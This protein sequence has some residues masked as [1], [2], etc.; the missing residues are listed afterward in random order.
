MIIINLE[1]P[2]KTLIQVPE[3]PEPTIRVIIVNVEQE[4]KNGSSK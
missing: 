1:P 2:K 4:P 3:T